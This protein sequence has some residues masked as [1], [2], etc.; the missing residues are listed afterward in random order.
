MGVYPALRCIYV[1]VPKAGSMAIHAALVAGNES[2]GGTTPPPHDHASI[3]EIQARDPKPERLADFYSFSYV[4]NPYA[5]LVSLFLN[6]RDE[7][8][9]EE[10]VERLASASAQALEDSR[11]KPQW[12]YLTI[13][14]RQAVQDVF[15]LEELD[16]TWG[17]AQRRIAEAS[18]GASVPVVVRLNETRC[19]QAPLKGAPFQDFYVPALQSRV[20]SLYA[21]DFEQLG[22]ATELPPR[23]S[24]DG[25]GPLHQVRRTVLADT[26]RIVTM[27][28]EG[29]RAAYCV[30]QA[31]R[32]SKS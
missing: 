5:R 17:V 14:G 23:P 3:E 4:R 24:A 8:T 2:A 26:R 31:K 32:V 19:E 1:Q 9:F 12:C 29:R 10:F 27:R 30:A 7:L 20:R 6:D 22:Y 25:A 16:A 21:P 11:S 13:A 18:G 15:R 28:V